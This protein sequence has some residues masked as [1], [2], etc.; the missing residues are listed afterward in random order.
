[1][2]KLDLN[3]KYVQRV[4]SFSLNAHFCGAFIYTDLLCKDYNKR[5]RYMQTKY[6]RYS[7]TLF[8]GEAI[9][10]QNIQEAKRCLLKV[11]PKNNCVNMFIGFRLVIIV[12]LNSKNIHVNIN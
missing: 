12:V 11:C 9:L 2:S 8:I 3:F 10:Q 5:W 6:F 4:R 7:K 1:M